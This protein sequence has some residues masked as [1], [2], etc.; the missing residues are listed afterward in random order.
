MS[1]SPANS[2]QQTKAMLA[3]VWNKNRD[4]LLH[5]LDSIESFCRQLPASASDD[6]LRA[7]ASSDAHKLA[8]SL[9]MFG[10]NEGTAVA[11]DIENRLRDSTPESLLTSAI[12]SL[13]A[14]LRTLVE[15]FQVSVAPPPA[16]ER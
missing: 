1:Q 10:L 14:Q 5:R 3:V 11:R 7:E 2:T 6:D 4:L 16:P 13:A 9:G 15:R 12:P 8:G